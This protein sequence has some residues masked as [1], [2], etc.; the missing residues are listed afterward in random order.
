MSDVGSVSVERGVEAG[1]EHTTRLGLGLFLV[2]LISDANVFS[3][4]ATTPGVINS[5]VQQRLLHVARRALP[6]AGFVGSGQWERW[7]RQ[8]PDSTP[9]EE[10]H[11]SQ[12]Q[13]NTLKMWCEGGRERKD[14]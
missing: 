2:P 10:L 7:T 6:L 1:R 12:S 8:E 5:D 11:V 9:M 3:E 13:G 4:V 14:S